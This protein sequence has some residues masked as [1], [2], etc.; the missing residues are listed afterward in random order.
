MKQEG[1]TFQDDRVA[2]VKIKN[3]FGVTAIHPLIV[4]NVPVIMHGMKHEVPSV[5]HH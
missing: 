5:V 1:A 3:Y 4:T 2:N